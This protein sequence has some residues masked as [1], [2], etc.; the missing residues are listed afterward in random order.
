MK[1]GINGMGRIGRLV[2]RMALGGI[3]IHPDDKNNKNL[4]IV[5]VNDIADSKTIA[6]LI[7]FDSLHGKW[8]NTKIHQEKNMIYFNDKK[9]SFSS[10]NSIEKVEWGKIGCDLVLDCSGKNLSVPKLNKYFAK[11]VKKVV[12]STPVIGL[13]VKN[14]VMG[15]NEIE[16][17]ASE[18]NLITASSCTTNCIAPIVKIIHEKFK[19]LKGQITTIH[20]LTNTNVTLD[21]HHKDLRRARSSLISMHPTTTGSAKAIGLIFPELEGKLNGHA[22]RVPVLN[23]S[24]TDCVFLVSKKTSKEEVNN[25]FDEASKNELKGILGIEYNPLVSVDFLDDTRSSIIDAESTMVTDG[26]LIKIYS[27]YDN[28]IGYSARMVDLANYIIK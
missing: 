12:V 25:F 6:H 19:I 2:L 18:N 26:T 13:G 17:S 4:N 3:K 10:E 7:Q 5:H 22:V 1:V 20:D 9:V 23:S 11:K 8:E 27:W 14:I 28:E 16:Y 24:L 21:Q 15:V